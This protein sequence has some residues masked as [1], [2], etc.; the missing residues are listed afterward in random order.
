MRE[1]ETKG[2]RFADLIGGVVKSVPFQM[3]QTQDTPKGA[4]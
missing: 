3:R 1:T 2:Y 4:S